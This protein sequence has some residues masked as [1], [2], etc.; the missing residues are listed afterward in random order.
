MQ[1]NQFV[2]SC[3]APKLPNVTQLNTHKKLAAH[4]QASHFEYA[5]QYCHFMSRC[6]AIG[7]QSILQQIIGYMVCQD[8][9]SQHEGSSALQHNVQPFSWQA[10]QDVV[11][12][13]P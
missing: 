12:A 2:L 9:E 3:Q 13:Q 1:L 5:H 7:F 4:N 8:W 10:P 11:T 6:H